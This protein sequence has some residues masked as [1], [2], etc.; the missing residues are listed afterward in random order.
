MTDVTV[1]YDDVVIEPHGTVVVLN[2]FDTDG[3]PVR[4][5]VDH[6]PAGHLIDHLREVGEVIVRVDDWQIL[7]RGE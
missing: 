3:V 1:V 7:G 4:F 6:R 2:G 5:G